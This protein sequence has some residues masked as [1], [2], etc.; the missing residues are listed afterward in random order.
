[1]VSKE[2][3]RAGFTC[4]NLISIIERSIINQRCGLGIL[5]FRAGFRG[6]GDQGFWVGVLGF[7]VGRFRALGF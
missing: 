6:F 1:M 2:F 5:G 7:R 4:E 3:S